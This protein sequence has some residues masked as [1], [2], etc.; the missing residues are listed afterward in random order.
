MAFCHLHVHSHFSI[1][2]GYGTIDELLAKAKEL[3]QPA[4]ALTDHGSTSG[5]WELQNKQEKYGVKAILGTEFYCEGVDGKNA[6]LVVFA[7]NNKGLEN[8][9][10][11]QEFAYVD[12]FYRKPRINDEV[13]F[14][15]NEG[16]IVS[17]ACLG[18]NIP[19]HILNGDMA[20]ATAL[21]K[22]YKRVFGD[23]FYIEIQ[24][25]DIP[26]QMVANKAL[27]RLADMLNIEIIATNDVH[28][29]NEEDW[30]P[31][32]VMLAMQ[33][34]K[35]WDNPKRFKF[36][37]HDLWLKSEEEM[38]KGFSYLPS[39]VVD[40]ALNNTLVI[41][42]RCNAYMEKGN[43]LPHYHGCDRK[44]ERDVLVGKV[45]K[46]VE[47]LGYKEHLNDIQHEINVID[48]EGYCGYFLIVADYINW[49]RE[50]GII[51]GD[52]RGSGAGSKVVYTTGISRV[53]PAPYNLLFERFLAHG[54]VPDI[55]TDF[56]NQEAVI[57]YLCSL[58]G[59]ENVARI[60]TFGT[61]AP[62]AVTR[63]VL[64]CFGFTQGQIKRI[65]AE[66]LE[67]DKSIHDSLKRSKKL[68]EYASKYKD[69]FELIS[70]LENRIS[71]SGQHAGGVVIW[72]GLS[73][74]LPV[75]TTSENRNRRIVAF[76][77]IEVEE[78]GFYK[79]DILG[80]KTVT[81][82]QKAIESIKE[83]EGIDVDL[84]NINYEDEK[85]YDMLCQGDLSGV[86]QLSNQS[87][88]IMEQKPRSFRDLIAI[89]ALIRP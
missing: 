74:V 36:P 14:K 51:V 63:K 30:Y 61:L 73:S 20:K 80:L 72:E 87:G 52:G 28:Y 13:L 81:V 55:D 46:G 65:N 77:K 59:E 58:Y 3:G 34:K 64:N 9:F 26:E 88:K 41:A 50:N 43:Y 86:F 24:P 42:D 62:K 68:R 79:F 49:A 56:S 85:V 89:N 16:L 1:L 38:R 7:M 69:E 33:S 10:K 82:V 32:E 71:H 45:K 18:G 75:M 27:V 35:K 37:T 39:D 47:K 22:E 2:D 11:L 70:M 66:I 83:V 4:I 67:K 12:N 78:L 21:A 25:N 40:K 23:R 17:S 53:D 57:E 84:H 29:V 15:H 8:V 48:E 44:D 5:I 6:H 76:D 54:R 31:H 60:V 19:K